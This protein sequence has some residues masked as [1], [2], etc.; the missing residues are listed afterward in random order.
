MPNMIAVS[1]SKG[2]SKGPKLVPFQDSK[3]TSLSC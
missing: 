3:N 1:N 2:I